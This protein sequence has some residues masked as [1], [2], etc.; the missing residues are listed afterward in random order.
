MKTLRSSATKCSSLQPQQPA[1]RHAARLRDH[2]PARRRAQRHD[3]DNRRLRICRRIGCSG[4]RRRLSCNLWH[5]PQRSDCVLKSAAN[6]KAYLMVKESSETAPTADEMK[7]RHSPPHCVPAKKCRWASTA[8]RA[9]RNTASTHCLKA[10]TAR[11]WAKL[12]QPTHS[13]PH[14]C[15]PKCLRSRT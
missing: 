7:L 6:G 10:S 14:I 5:Q 9:R 8:C 12:R 1:Q 4:I 3:T 13:Q 2:R 15:L 11:M